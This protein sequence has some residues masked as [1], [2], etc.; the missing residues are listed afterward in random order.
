MRKFLGN[1]L[2]TCLVVT[3]ALLLVTVIIAINY[4]YNSLN[5]LEFFL[6]WLII[7]AVS[8]SL[9]VVIVDVYEKLE[10]A[11]FHKNYKEK[12]KHKQ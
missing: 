5:N 11:Q 1:H 8:G 12:K 9:L 3:L 10:I 6:V 2:L 7:E 4:A